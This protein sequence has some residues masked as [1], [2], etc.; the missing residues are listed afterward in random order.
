MTADTRRLATN[1]TLNGPGYYAFTNTEWTYW[2]NVDFRHNEI[3]NVGFADG[4]AKGL[5]P[6][7]VFGPDPLP[8]ANLPPN[9]V[10]AVPV[11]NR[12]SASPAQITFWQKA[13]NIPRGDGRTD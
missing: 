1:A 4:H 5:R 6:A 12:A 11:A 13:W 7:G 9:F 3:A 8:A 2:W 10:G